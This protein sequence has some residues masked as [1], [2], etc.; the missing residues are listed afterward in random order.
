MAHSRGSGLLGKL[1]IVCFGL[2]LLT[3]LF[4]GL[5][6]DPNS[7]PSPLVGKPAPDFEVVDLKS[8][9]AFLLSSLQGQPV[10]LNFW[11]SWCFACKSEAAQLE[12][13]HQK[14][15]GK[16]LVFGVAVQDNIKDARMF[17][18]RYGKTY[19]LALDTTGNANTEYGITG[20]PETFVIDA[21]G[22]ITHKHVG[23]ITE[24]EILRYLEQ[25]K[26]K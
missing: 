22:K 10:I 6:F 12:A 15:A 14:H 20:V 25:N 4:I 21:A 7:I 23:P 5:R 26:S 3:V 9:K 8:E 24:Q 1:T 17:A 2:A 16:A 11:A 13:F 19:R 18:T